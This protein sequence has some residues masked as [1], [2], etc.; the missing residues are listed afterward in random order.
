MEW[1]LAVFSYLKIS[2]ANLYCKF[3]RQAYPRLRISCF[4]HIHY[5]K[6]ME[7]GIP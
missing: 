6:T 2:K 1:L 3:E 5:H 7:W 4:S